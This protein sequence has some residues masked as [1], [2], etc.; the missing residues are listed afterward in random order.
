MEKHLLSLYQFKNQ[1]IPQS[2]LAQQIGLSQ[3][4]LSRNLKRW[5]SEGIL[6][7]RSGKGR[8][9][10]SIINW[11][12]DIE[13]DYYQQVKKLLNHGYSEEALP[14][15]SW[16]WSSLAHQK[17]ITKSNKLLGFTKTAA[18]EDRLT[19][20]KRHSLLSTRPFEVL[21]AKNASVLMSVYDTLFKVT[22]DHH[23]TFKLA[24][25]YDLHEHSIDI[26]LRPHVRFHD[27]SYL[28]SNDV[29]HTLEYAMQHSHT[30]DMLDE[31][32]D[33]HLIDELS[34]TIYFG[35]CPQIL[36]LLSSVSLSI[37]KEIDGRYIGTGPYFIKRDNHYTTILKRFEGYYNSTAFIDEIEMVYIPDIKEPVIGDPQQP[38][39]T[40]TKN[41]GFFYMCQ[42]P[43]SQLT[44]DQ[45]QFLKFI[46]KEEYYALIE[47]VKP[48]VLN[49]SR[50]IESQELSRPAFDAPVKIDCIEIKESSR[51]AFQ[52]I[53]D[54][55]DIPF[56]LINHPFTVSIDRKTDL[57]GDYY[58]FG[59]YLDIP[60]SLA[61]YQFL[62]GAS[63]SIHRLMRGY[64]WFE[65]IRQ[66]YQRYPY[67]R[68]GQLNRLVDRKLD[69]YAIFYPLYTVP[70]S[71]TF[72]RTL[73]GLSV[74]QY[75]FI[76]FYQIWRKPSKKASHH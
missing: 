36:A 32:N 66:L 21:E 22:D 29:K 67:E 24:H 41:I 27:G 54:R 51:E 11:H 7:Y 13:E 72:D 12:T 61:Y 28:T 18:N 19:I 60:E 53:F 55:Y 1:P 62:F 44:A 33:I 6:S 40:L 74:N 23:V 14:Y 56:E 8:G 3:K 45:K 20:T 64:K 37:F 15:L 47:A 10:Y 48:K 52:A 16:P 63:S 5:Q 25:H 34:L 76:D 75:G 71:L 46:L 31:V 35:R 73:E 30:Q 9:Q 39:T 42:N 58:F 2:Q 59:E 70:V 38:S 17:L 26:Y 68:W 50:Y 43:E 49:H 4:Q 69:Q 65:S 57:S